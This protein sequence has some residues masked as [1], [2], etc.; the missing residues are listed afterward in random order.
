MSIINC[1]EC[2][3]QVDTDF[4]DAYTSEDGGDL[5]ENCSDEKEVNNGRKSNR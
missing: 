5:C 3:K 4:E 1:E 2:S